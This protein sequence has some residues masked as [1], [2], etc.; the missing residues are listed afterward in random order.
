M[1]WFTAPEKLHVE[2]TQ[3][4]I[5]LMQLKQSSEKIIDIILKIDQKSTEKNSGQKKGGKQK[6]AYYRSNRLF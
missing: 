2:S 6:K 3:S 1:K 5:Y 4:I